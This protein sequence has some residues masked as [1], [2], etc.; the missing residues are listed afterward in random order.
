MFGGT[1][2]GE[3]DVEEECNAHPCPGIQNMTSVCNQ[4]DRIFI[5]YTFVTVL[6]LYKITFIVNC[7]WNSW[8]N[9]DCSVSCGGGNRTK[10]R[11][12][13]IDEQ[14]GGLCKEHSV[15]SEECN[16]DECPRMIFLS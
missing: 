13:N 6:L 15:A 12:K 8:E 7:E 4:P 11:S 14:F 9:G 3:H 16:M 1:C 10:T 5:Q 2:E